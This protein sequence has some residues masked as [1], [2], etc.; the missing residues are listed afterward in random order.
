MQ[1]NK[2]SQVVKDVLLDILKLKKGQA[3]KM[4]RKNEVWPFEAGH[5]T[6]LQFYCQR[7]DCAL[8]CLGN[9]NKKR[10]HNLVLGR[11]FN[12]Q[13][14]DMVEF[15][16]TKHIPITSFPSTTHIQVGTKV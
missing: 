8:F 14:L 15:G 2:V 16:I 11:V 3:Y 1:G 5:D 10:P 13:L 12:A 6:T 4:T 9:H 7:S